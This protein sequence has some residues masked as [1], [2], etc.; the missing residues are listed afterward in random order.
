MKRFN[1]VILA[2]HVIGYRIAKFLSH[3]PD[4]NI[5]KIYTNEPRQESWWTPLSNY[6]GLSAVCAYY[7]TNEQLYEEIKSLPIDLILALSWKHYLTP[8]L[9]SL[10][11][12]GNVNLHYSL[13]PKHRG[14]YPVNWAIIQGERE[15]GVTLHW[16]DEKFDAGD[17]IAQR[18]VELNPWDTSFDLLQ[19]LDEAALPLFSQ[20]WEQVAEWKQLAKR[21]SGSASY[22]SREQFH[23]LDELD[24]EAEMKIGD[25]INLLRGKS[26]PPAEKQIFFRDRTTGSKIFV[27]IELRPE[28]L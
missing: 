27:S 18:T 21:Q 10:P 28:R 2:D 25:L 11:M 14:V 9:L 4:A 23:A 7:R 15:T 3:R 22:H 24:L 26:F 19:R 17:I 6:E 16:M 5:L 1:L 12:V 8:R 13:L 20:L